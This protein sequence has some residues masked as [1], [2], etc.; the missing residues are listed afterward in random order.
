MSIV[1]F[2]TNVC[3]KMN[4]SALLAG[5]GGGQLFVFILPRH[6]S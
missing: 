2:T 6:T 5:L 1:K 4:C 3:I